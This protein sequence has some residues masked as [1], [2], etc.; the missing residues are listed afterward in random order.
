MATISKYQKQLNTTLNNFYQKPV[1]KTSIELFLT[2]ALVLFLAIF[3]IKP[4]LITMSDLVKEIDDKKAYLEKLNTKIAS[5]ATAQTE[6]ANFEDKLQLLEQAIPSSPELVHGLKIVEKLASENNVVISGMTVSELPTEEGEN[7]RV[8]ARVLNTLP[9][10]I[11]VVGDYISIRNFTEAIK[12]N[13]RTYIIESVSFNLNKDDSERILNSSLT[14]SMPYYG[15]PAG[16]SQQ[17]VNK[18]DLSEFGIDE[19]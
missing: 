11:N 13:R 7:A 6:Y 15:L 16:G 8:S 19:E 17:N 18:E 10:N 4:T 12:R 1:A 14:M 2:V 9:I 3:A 5:L